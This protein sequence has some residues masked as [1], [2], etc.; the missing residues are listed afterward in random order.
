MLVLSAAACGAPSQPSATPASSVPTDS[1][2]PAQVVETLLVADRTFAAV[3]AEVDLVSGLT[4][5]FDEDVIM[6]TAD[7]HFTRGKAAARAALDATA[8]NRESRVSWTAVRAGVSADGTHGFTFGYMTLTRPDGTIAPGKYLAYWVKRPGGWRVAVYRRGP[9][10][11]GD[12]PAGMMPPAAPPRMVAP[13]ADEATVERFRAELE[14][15]ERAFS[16]EAQVIGL[17]AAFAKHGSPDAVNLGG[18][19]DVAFVVGPEAIARSVSANQPE[20]GGSTVSWAPEHVLVA[21][22]G[23]LGVTIGSITRNPGPSQVTAGAAIPFFTIW[24]RG[25]PG[26]P[27]RYVAE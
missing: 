5:M 10:P 2:D 8:E 12:V 1:E 11:E 19:A 17:G 23:D 26:E 14:R 18:P 4:A 15:A 22:S 24:R 20:S 13:T 16:D 6:A 27:W 3:S 9:R 25:G 21:S 7:Q